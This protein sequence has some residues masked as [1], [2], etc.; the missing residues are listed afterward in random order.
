MSILQMTQNPEGYFLGTLDGLNIS[1]REVS[2][3]KIEGCGSSQE[4]SRD[5][6]EKIGSSVGNH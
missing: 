5:C 2:L 3:L 1:E 6:I 4:I